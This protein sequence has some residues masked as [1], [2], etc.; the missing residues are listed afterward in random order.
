MESSDGGSPMQ[1]T[2]PMHRHILRYLVLS[3]PLFFLL[4]FFFYPLGAIL[5]RSFRWSDLPVP[6]NLGYL[7]RVLWFTLWQA[8]ASTLLTLLLGLPGAHVFA[9]YRF[10]G[11]SLLQALTTV[12][13]VLPTLIVATA[14]SSL[15]GPNGVVNTVLMRAFSLDAPPLDLQHTIWII[16]LAHV[17]YNYSVVLRVVGSFWANLNPRLEEAARALGASRWRAWWEITLPQLM[18]SIAAASLLTFLFCFTSF[19]VVMI[20]GGPRLVTIEVEIYRQAI[21]R[22]NLPLAAILALVQLVVTFAIMSAYTTLQ[23]HAARP[24]DYRSRMVVQIK[25]TSWRTRAWIAANVTLMATL[26]LVPL[27]ALAWRSF[28]LGGTFTLR[29]YKA[30][31]QDPG[32]SIF[33]TPPPT[34]IRN[35]LL[36]ALAAVI[37]SLV[38]GTLGAY[39]LASRDA[40]LRRA[41]TWLDP[42]LVLPLG[43]SAVTLGFGYLV[44]FSRPPI[45]WITSLF[46]VPVVHALIAFPFV[47]RSVLPA[48]RGI[49]PSLGEAAATLGATPSRVWWAIDLPLIAR[50]LAVGAVF[51][52][53]ISI[54]EFGATLLIARTEY[55]TIPVTLYRYLSQP[56]PINVGQA[57][58]MSVLLMIICATSFL[59]IEH[60]RVGEIGTF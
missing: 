58:A 10:P 26:L 31:W 8:A 17:F 40:R 21:H 52:F 29:Y 27:F 46:L 39:L 43:A 38:L 19:G 13:F 11:K 18:P 12:P 47:L 15:V 16:L 35:S 48:L 44:A 4:L 42:L 20:L 50:S 33:F 49:R 37:L 57:L 34:A 32:H 23:R 3:L 9:R 28:T 51:S 25:P 36:F 2:S 55:A 7:A 1:C 60:L 54:G 6:P 41:V 59:L 45:N 5:V 24:L 30:L 53:T 14:F 22:L 56:G